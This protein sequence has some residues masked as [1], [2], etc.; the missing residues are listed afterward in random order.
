MSTEEFIKERITEE[1]I[2]QKALEDTIFNNLLVVYECQLRTYGGEC[3]SLLYVEKKLLNRFPKDSVKAV[4]D[5]AKRSMSQTLGRTKE[6]AELVWQR[7]FQ[8]N[9]AFL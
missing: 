6:L 2:L 9:K 5:S 4:V 7:V 1:Q 8:G 3:A